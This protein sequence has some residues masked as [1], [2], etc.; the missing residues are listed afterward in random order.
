MAISIQEVQ[1]IAKLAKLTFTEAELER[2]TREL[3]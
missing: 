1:H 3:N 2:F